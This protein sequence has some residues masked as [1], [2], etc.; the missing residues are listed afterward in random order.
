MFRLMASD[1]IHR[2]SKKSFKLCPQLVQTLKQAPFRYPAKVGIDA[3]SEGVT[4]VESLMSLAIAAAVSAL[5]LVAYNSIITFIR[6]TDV[7]AKSSQAIDNEVSRIRRLAQSYNA[8]D[9]PT[10]S[11][12]ATSSG[13]T[14]YTEANS[15]FYFPDPAVSANVNSFDSSCASSGAP[16]AHIVDAFISKINSEKY[17]TSTSAGVQFNATRLNSSNVDDHSVRVS[18]TAPGGVSRVLILSP[19]LSFWCR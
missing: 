8:C 11:F 16:S 14:G 17:A 1:M 4:I 18:F 13:C 3:H 10:G 9:S 19:Y 15:Y 5:A 2:N 7:Q 6:R 12:E